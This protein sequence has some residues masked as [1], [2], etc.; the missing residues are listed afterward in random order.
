[1]SLI[2]VWENPPETFTPVIRRAEVWRGYLDQPH[3]QQSR[4]T[5]LE[6]DSPWGTFEDNE[7]ARLDLPYQIRYIDGNDSQIQYI[8]DWDI[9]RYIRAD[10]TCRIKFTFREADGSMSAAKSIE[11][12]DEPCGSSFHRTILT[13][14]RGYAEFFALWDQRLL[15]R[16][17]GAYRA[18]DCI[19]PRQREIEWPD[20][21]KFGSVIATDQRGYV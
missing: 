14:Y 15:F 8:N 18:L 21:R 11:I 4:W 12:S 9:R 16:I 20:L 1:M 13:N 5:L 6:K 2:L 10:D 17:D 3:T 19:I 7:N